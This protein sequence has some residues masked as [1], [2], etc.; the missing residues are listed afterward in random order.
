MKINDEKAKEFNLAEVKTCLGC[1]RHKYLK[2]EGHWCALGV[3]KQT[4]YDDL[5]WDVYTF[6]EHFCCAKWD[7]Q[8]V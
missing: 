2:D 3:W 1:N 8:A 6:L 4:L 5:P 7:K